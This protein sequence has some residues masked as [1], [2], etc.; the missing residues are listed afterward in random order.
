MVCKKLYIATL[1]KFKT[2]SSST[3]QGKQLFMQSTVH[4]LSTD[5]ETHNRN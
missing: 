4:A 5:N 2:V 1:F 3:P